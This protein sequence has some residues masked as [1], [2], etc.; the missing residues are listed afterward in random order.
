MV[1]LRS[2]ASGL[3]VVRT[4]MARLKFDLVAIVD[5]AVEISLSM[6]CAFSSWFDAEEQSP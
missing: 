4:G 1:V 6:P 2:E 5:V 3:D